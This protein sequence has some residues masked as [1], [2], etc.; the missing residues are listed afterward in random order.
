MAN[1]L[2]KRGLHSALPA[3]NAATDGVFYLTTDTNRLYVGQGTK[4]VELNK[5]I[6]V[7]DTIAGLPALT[8]VEAGQFYYVKGPNAG[9]DNVQNGNILAVCVSDGT[10][11]RWVQ[12]NPD[13]NTDTGYNYISSTASVSGNGG[14]VVDPENHRIAYTITF[15]QMHKDGNASSAASEGDVTATFYVN[16]NDINSIVQ[17][18]EVSFGASAVSTATVAGGS[19]TLNVGGSNASGDG[20]VVNAGQNVTLTGGGN[21][22]LVINAVDTKYD[23]ESAA[24]SKSIVLKEGNQSK[25]TVNFAAG[26]ALEVSEATAGTI[27][28]NHADV[29]ASTSGGDAT[30]QSTAT[31]QNAS[32]NATID[33]VESVVVNAQG[34]V[35][36][37][38]TK[39]ITA[40]DTYPTGGSI[41][42][43]GEA[44]SGS[45]ALNNS[46]SVTLTGSD[47]A[48]YHN[49]T[50]TDAGATTGTVVKVSNQGTLT[51]NLYSAAKVDELIAGLNAMTY[52]GTVGTDGTVSALPTSQVQLGDTYMV[53]TAGVGPNSNSQPGDLYIAVGTEDS[54]GYITSSTLSWEHVAAGADKDTTYTFTVASDGTISYTPSTSQSSTTL[55]KVTADRDLTSDVSGST[56]TIKHA[57]GLVTAG[58]KGDNSSV[59]NTVA[60][61]DSF[62][63][64]KVTVNAQGHVTGL[65]EKTITLPA[66]I[67]S[68]Y[69]LSTDAN[70]STANSAKVV[71]TASGSSSGTTNA[72]ISS[73]GVVTVSGSSSGIS[74]GHANKFSGTAGAFGPTANVSKSNTDASAS[75]VVPQ[76]TVDAQGHVTAVSERS[77]SLADK[78]T[79]YAWT[80]ANITTAAATNG[81]SGTIS[82]TPTVGGTAAAAIT[83]SFSAVSAGQSVKITPAANGAI[84]FE[85]EWGTF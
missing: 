63:I 40:K 73:D 4:L 44:I 61:G 42:V 60:Y 19:T 71:L 26:T 69:A 64:P 38:A 83:T 33:V 54:S 10:T 79:T 22:P 77:I 39:T 28:Y 12:V 58:T 56:I 9:A 27:S 68:K 34:H 75:F 82:L 1:V 31:A 6:T 36:N 47:N 2:F 16:S 21:A 8:D 30:K 41:T 45:V 49:L 5:S 55:A 11:K 76:I 20:V 14:G 59:A 50:I 66:S 51:T 25:A 52:K 78:D 84:N 67:D 48:L 17:N 24:N 72:I 65:T 57:T 62:V 46:S 43:N 7:V 29:A 80:A 37:V 3:E 23:L 53:K 81:V 15:T 74:I 70:G 85:I 35:T 32:N 18:V 13:T